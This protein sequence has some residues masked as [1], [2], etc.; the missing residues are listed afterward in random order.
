MRTTR[1]TSGRDAAA[2]TAASFAHRRPAS[3]GDTYVRY[4]GADAGSGS[5]CVTVIPAR[6]E[7]DKAAANGVT[8]VPLGEDADISR[9]SQRAIPT[10]AAKKKQAGATRMQATLKPHRPGRR[11]Q[12]RARARR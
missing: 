3:D 11:D 12:Q 6:T 5:T 7:G 10:A 9:P 4:V 8:F 2:D 1:A